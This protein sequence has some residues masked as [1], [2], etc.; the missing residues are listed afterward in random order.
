MRHGFIKASDPCVGAGAMMVALAQEMKENGINYQQCLHVSATDIDITAVHMAYIQFTL[1]NI[2][3]VI[4]WGNTLTLEEWGH[5][6]TFA[7]IT[8]RWQER[9][10]A[11]ER[12]ERMIAFMKAMNMDE[13][14]PAIETVTIPLPSEPL[15][16]EPEQSIVINKP[17]PGEQ[18]T[19]F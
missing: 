13:P 8:G 7:H 16:P 11:T 12:V 5:W 4:T 1:F 2:P 19:L 6:Y 14:P 15:T 10:D 3:A 18:I 9:I 17:T